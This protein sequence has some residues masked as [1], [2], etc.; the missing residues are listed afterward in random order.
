[1]PYIVLAGQLSFQK[2]KADDTRVPDGPEEIVRKGGQVPDYAP[3]FLVGALASAGLVVW[4]EDQ[5]PDL[6]PFEELPAQ[7]RTPDQPPVLPS[8]PNGTPPLLSDILTPDEQRPAEVEGGDVAP[9]VEPEPAV[10]PLP[11]LPKAADS[12]DV[13][14]QYATH[15]RIGMTLGEAEAKN[16]T[17]LMAEVKRR[18]EAANQ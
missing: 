5:R 10:A 1:M 8:D 14:E 11:A 13:W 2:T 15:P 9:V 12:K 3:A 4:A 18:Y 7:V 16:K 6:V 17:D